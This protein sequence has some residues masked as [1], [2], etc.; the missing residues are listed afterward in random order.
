MLDE[1]ILEIEAAEGRELRKR[2]RANLK[3]EVIQTL[4]PRALTRSHLTYAFLAESRGLLLIDSSS[5]ARAE[6]LLNLLRDSGVPHRVAATG[7]NYQQSLAAGRSYLL[8]RVRIDPAEE[9][10][11]EISGHRLM[12]LVRLMRQDVEGRLKPSGSNASFELT[13][14]A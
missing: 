5:P 3:D 2:E 11:P 6:D 12:V 4:L 13:L 10:V 9:L 14:C 7:G 8:L 1:K